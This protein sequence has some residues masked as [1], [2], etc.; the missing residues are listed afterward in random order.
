M[1]SATCTATLIDVVRFSV[2][3]VVHD[4]SDSF[5]K[6]DKVEILDSSERAIHTLGKV[7]VLT[8]WIGRNK[9]IQDIDHF[10]TACLQSIIALHSLVKVF[11]LMNR[12]SV[13]LRVA[14]PEI[15]S[16][17]QVLLTANFELPTIPKQV[18][19]YYN[20]KKTVE[21]FLWGV[22]YTHNSL[23]KCS[24]FDIVCGM[25]YIKVD[26]NFECW[27]TVDN[28]DAIYTKT[29]V[30]WRIVSVN[31][32]IP[33]VIK[34]D[35]K[36]I[37]HLN[38]VLKQKTE[39]LKTPFPGLIN[40]FL[41]TAKNMH[42]QHLCLEAD[43]TR[44]KEFFPNLVAKISNGMNEK[45]LT[46]HY[47]NNEIYVKYNFDV[48]NNKLQITHSPLLSTD[49]FDVSLPLPQQITKLAKA[50]VGM[51]CLKLSKQL[52]PFEGKNKARTTFH[53]SMYTGKI[54]INTPY[55]PKPLVEHYNILV[56]R[57]PT[58][59]FTALL[60]DLHTQIKYA[61]IYTIAKTYFKGYPIL[62]CDDDTYNIIKTHI[63]KFEK[64]RGEYLVPKHNIANAANFEICGFPFLVKMSDSRFV[65]L[66]ITKKYDE[67]S[68]KDEDTIIW[69]VLKDGALNYS[70]CSKDVFVPTSTSTCISKIDK[71]C[72][73]SDLECKKCVNT[74]NFKT[75]FE[76]Q[77]K[78]E[79]FT[80]LNIG[81]PEICLEC[82]YLPY[83]IYLEQIT[84][85]Q[86]YTI[87]VSFKPFKDNLNVLL[88]KGNSV[89]YVKQKFRFTISPNEFEN[90][91]RV[92][93]DKVVVFIHVLMLVDHLN[94]NV[95]SFTENSVTVSNSFVIKVTSSLIDTM[96][97]TFS[98]TQP[99]AGLSNMF[100][101]VFFPENTPTALVP[102]SKKALFFTSLKTVAN[103]IN[104]ILQLFYNANR[105]CL[106]ITISHLNFLTICLSQTSA[107]VTESNVTA[108]FSYNISTG[109]KSATFLYKSAGFFNLCPSELF[110]KTF[111][112]KKIFPSVFNM[113]ELL[114][115]LKNL[116]NFLHTF[117]FVEFVC[118][119]REMKNMM[120]HLRHDLVF[121]IPKN[122]METV[123]TSLTQQPHPDLLTKYFNNRFSNPFKS[124]QFVM[125]RQLVIFMQSKVKLI[126]AF[127][128][129]FN[130]CLLS[131][132]T[133]KNIFDF[134]IDES[135]PHVLFS[136]KKFKTLNELNSD[137]FDFRIMFKCTPPHQFQ[138]EGFQPQT[139][140]TRTLFEKIQ[141]KRI[142]NIKQV[143]E[144]IGE[145]IN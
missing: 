90:P 129:L 121:E 64:I 103:C 35:E 94:E 15:P 128:P 10:N 131:Q 98:L 29:D 26:Q 13:A 57:K 61:Q 145:N 102:L 127:E 14:F 43:S 37:A 133:P 3:R 92:L 63:G 108:I 67:V 60:V 30:F 79:N 21:R 134:S 52:V 65:T 82:R 5:Q 11:V 45:T 56:S 93:L 132:N 86:N 17:L 73:C 19:N 53:I 34:T 22:Y 118:S 139:E 123:S 124:G 8:R 68:K 78:A 85:V 101:F 18:P 16:A 130:F 115:H 38:E 107:V 87:N 88:V 59:D 95:T 28:Q 97:L 46:I 142:D 138:L 6:C 24:K 126:R 62:R 9:V 83:L 122:F 117:L 99:Y 136:V 27:I 75:R 7:L 140:N 110:T 42:F 84:E 39:C 47:W 89:E 55:L 120:I 31:F 74:D 48:K 2:S 135:T 111:E 49:Y 32:Y 113:T 100:S 70:Y 1:E 4:I 119:D 69:I 33:H 40:Y 76:E 54:N 50:T 143:V 114:A 141:M 125:A 72:D 91:P 66:A 105:S 36:T 58:A 44:T 25:M 80:Q 106:S 20:I 12:K 51:L 77:F 109:N 104:Q 137:L 112:N 41:Y 144:I 116:V 81:G 71:F 96:V 23:I